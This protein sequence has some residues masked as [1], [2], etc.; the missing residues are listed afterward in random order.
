MDGMKDGTGVGRPLGLARRYGRT[1]GP[2]ITRE[3]HKCSSQIVCTAAKINKTFA[4]N[5][6][7]CII[8]W[9]RDLGNSM[10]VLVMHAKQY[11]SDNFAPWEAH[12]T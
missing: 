9:E 11:V 10:Y 1:L 12:Q 3:R 2:Q 7:S 5:T 4:D 8:N 6:D